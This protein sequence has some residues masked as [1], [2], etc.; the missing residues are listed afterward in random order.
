M[1]RLMQMMMNMPVALLLIKI[2]VSKDHVV[3]QKGEKAVHLQ[4]M[5][6]VMVMPV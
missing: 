6:I 1:T 2:L 3:I 4:T 5:V